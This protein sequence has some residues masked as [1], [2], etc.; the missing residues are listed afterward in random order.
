VHIGLS[1][2]SIYLC[3]DEEQTQRWLPAMMRFETIGS[4]GFSTLIR[5]IN[6]RSPV[7]ICGRPACGRDFQR[8]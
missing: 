2:G 5:R 7:S 8:Q 4:C 1:A 6:L 3:G